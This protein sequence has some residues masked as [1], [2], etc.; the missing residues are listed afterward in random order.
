MA[1]NFDLIFLLRSVVILS[2]VAADYFF[3]LLICV[4]GYCFVFFKGQGTVFFLL[5]EEGS[6][7]ESAFIAI[8]WVVFVGK[9]LDVVSRLLKQVQLD[10]FL[11]D[12]EQPRG[13][14]VDPNAPFGTQSERGM[15]KS[16]VSVWRKLFVANEWNELQVSRLVN[17][18]LSLIFLLF[19]LRGLN[20]EYLATSQPAMS[21]LNPKAAPINIL[22]RFFVSSFTLLA[23]ASLQLIYRQLIYHRYF[24]DEAA[25]F[26]DF[27]TMANISIF[28]MDEP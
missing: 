27:L 5:P 24:S 25:D 17:V 10:I 2:S 4:T 11:I 13:F 8:L 7:A 3:W 6:G 15:K 9:I 14:E 28:L 20:L 18:E 26:V 1:D 16:P 12:W 22:L 19:F 21:E 23:A